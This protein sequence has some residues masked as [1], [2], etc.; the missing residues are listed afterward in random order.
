MFIR[1]HD[2]RLSAKGADEH[3]Q[4]R[5]RQVEVGQESF[6]DSEFV[7][8]VN[9]DIGFTAAGSNS[10]VSYGRGVLQGADGSGAHGD[11]A[12]T[13]VQGGINGV[14]SC[15][16]DRVRLAMQMVIFDAF[17]AH[18]LKGSQPDVQRN[19]HGF[20]S[21]FANGR[22]NFR[23]EVQTCGGRSDRPVFTRIDGLVSLSVGSTVGAV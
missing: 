3:K 11:N 10:T 19:F 15:G 12:P 21:P 13:S 17:D 23:G 16:G 4:R 5:L 18:R 6:S 9:E 8:R 14:R 2:S 20:D 22:Q 7:S 1:S